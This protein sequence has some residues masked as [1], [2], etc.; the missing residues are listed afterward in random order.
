MHG[1]RQGRPERGPCTALDVLPALGVLPTDARRVGRWHA[2]ATEL[3]YECMIDM[4]VAAASW[5]GAGCVK[6]GKV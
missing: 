2:E 4:M 3:F 6:S 5:H 1:G